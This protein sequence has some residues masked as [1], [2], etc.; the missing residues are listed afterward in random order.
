M[1]S[2]CAMVFCFLLGLGMLTGCK[3]PMTCAQAVIDVTLSP[4]G[5]MVNVQKK[6]TDTKEVQRLVSF[7]PHLGEGKRS[8]RTGAW[9][10]CASVKFTGCDGRVVTVQTN[11]SWWSEGP[12]DWPMDEG[13]S[14][15]IRSLLDHVDQTSTNPK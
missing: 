4:S 1:K 7:F 15:Y 6:V 12:G 10:S 3:K 5:K 2:E 9:Q 14:T 8:S 13:F 11:Y